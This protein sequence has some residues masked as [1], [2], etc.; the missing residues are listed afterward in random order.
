VTGTTKKVDFGNKSKKG[1]CK[2]V[3]GGKVCCVRRMW[4]ESIRIVEKKR[5]KGEMDRKG[6]DLWGG[7]EEFE[8]EESLKMKSAR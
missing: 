4:W 7:V 6:G 3:E 5:R 1:G 2:S 8:R